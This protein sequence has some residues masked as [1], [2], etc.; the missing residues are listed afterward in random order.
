MADNNTSTV[1]KIADYV[2]FLG[3]MTQKQWEMFMYGRY[4][5]HLQSKDPKVKNKIYKVLTNW[6]E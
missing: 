5:K 2:Q 6:F 4:E 1:Y 3:L